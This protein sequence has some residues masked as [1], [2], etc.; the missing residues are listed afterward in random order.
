MRLQRIFPTQIDQ[1]NN[2]AREQAQRIGETAT[3]MEQMN[4]SVWVARTLPAPRP[5]P[6]RQKQKRP[7]GL[8]SSVRS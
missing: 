8:L 3:S 4:A 1:S 2:G 7:K 6:I 5:Q